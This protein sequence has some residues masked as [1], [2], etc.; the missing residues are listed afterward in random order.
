MRWRTILLVCILFLCG[1]QRSGNTLELKYGQSTTISVYGVY[2]VIGCEWLESVNVQPGAQAV[3]KVEMK[4]PPRPLSGV[5]QPLTTQSTINGVAEHYEGWQ[6]EID[7]AQRRV[8]YRGG[9]LMR[10]FE[11]GDDGA[12]RISDSEEAGE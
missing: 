12:V 9:P 7:D 1:C 8:V 5:P 11:F 10:T 2:K 6:V 4:Q 3:V